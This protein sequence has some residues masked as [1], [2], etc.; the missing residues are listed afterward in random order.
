MMIAYFG[1]ARLQNRDL[2]QWRVSGDSWAQR[3]GEMFWIE[4]SSKCTAVFNRPCPAAICTSTQLSQLTA[5]HLEVVA[6]MRKGALNILSGLWVVDAHNGIDGT[7][8][9]GTNQTWSL[10]TQESSWAGRR[11]ISFLRIISLLGET[12]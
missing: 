11:K 1:L 10:R 2:S 8:V 5:L 4:L 9:V 12:Q 6:D 3:H 7:A